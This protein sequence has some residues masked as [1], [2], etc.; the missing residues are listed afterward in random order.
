ME[1]EGRHAGTGCLYLGR[2]L[3][4][5][6]LATHALEVLVLFYAAGVFLEDLADLEV[7]VNARLVRVRGDGEGESEGEW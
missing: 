7:G 4:A 6:H 5:R 1:A 3:A 2:A